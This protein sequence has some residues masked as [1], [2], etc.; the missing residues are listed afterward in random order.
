[1]KRYLDYGDRWYHFEASK[2]PVSLADKEWD[3]GKSKQ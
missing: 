3:T 2:Q 1:M